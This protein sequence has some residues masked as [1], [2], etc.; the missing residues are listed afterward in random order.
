MDEQHWR[1]L[2]ELE[3]LTGDRLMVCDDFNARSTHWGNTADNTRG[4]ALSNALVKMNLSAVNRKQM[5]RLPI[6]E[7]DSDSNIDPTPISTQALL[8]IHWEALAYVGS[9]HLPCC[10]RIKKGGSLQYKKLHLSMCT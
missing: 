7:S 3:D 5:T 9:D 2:S 1:F 8:D 10:V 6:R 4:R